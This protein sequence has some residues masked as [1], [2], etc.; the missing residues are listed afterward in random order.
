M[1]ISFD[2]LPEAIDVKIVQKLK[3]QTYVTFY[4]TFSSSLPYIG[5]SIVI[6]IQGLCGRKYGAVK[7]GR[8]LLQTLESIQKNKT[9]TKYQVR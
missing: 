2:I 9:L 5:L 1:F 6:L 4:W 8:G 3:Y 7:G